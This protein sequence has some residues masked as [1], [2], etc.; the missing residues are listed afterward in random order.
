V[1]F[2]SRVCIL[3]LT[4][5]VTACFNPAPAPTDA[6]AN[7][8]LDQVGDGL[9]VLN[10][11]AVA[12]R[13]Y[14]VFYNTGTD[15]SLNNYSR[16]LL[17]ATPPYVLAGLTNGT[18]YAFS[19]TSTENGSSVGPFTPVFTATP[20]L[21]SPSTPWTIGTPLGTNNLNS[22]IL[23]VSTVTNTTNTGIISTYVTVGDAATIFYGT[24]SY[25]DVGGVTAWTQATGLPI[26]TSTNLK[27]VIYD[28][29][30][31]I[32]LGDDG[33][34]IRSTDYT[35]V[36]WESAAAITSPSAM[37]SMAVGAG[38]Y[39]AVGNGGAIYLNT[40]AGAGSAWT[41]ENTGYSSNLYNV[42]YVNGLF[43][44]VGASGTIL[45]SSD[46][47]NWKM[48]TSNLSDDLY[49]VAYGASTTKTNAVGGGISVTTNPGSYIVVGNTGAVASSP[50]AVNWTA[51]N[52]TISNGESFRS[53]C[54]GPDQQF[55][56]VGT[57]GLVAYSSTG[58]DGSWTTSTVGATSPQGSQTLNSI[59][60]NY[61]FIA[62]GDLGTNVSGK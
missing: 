18:Q 13:K 53:I 27:S 52:N 19:I 59:S 51:E 29:T 22:I 32:A 10:W 33:S 60:P 35:G 39:V 23:G 30:R 58:L 16:I 49:G 56:A 61:L 48:Q 41:E 42:S 1:K 17:G 15:V 2:L 55:I 44:A 6:P 40:S 43:I 11:D 26:S 57:N 47:A 3:L 14:W 45:T 5:S 31:F 34:V 62:T 20:R 8:S 36:A 54:Y 50:D 21:V 12:G 38:R 9:V 7:A 28:G 46:G 4:L 37:N 24:Y 25:P